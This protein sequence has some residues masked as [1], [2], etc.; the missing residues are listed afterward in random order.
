MTNKQITGRDK[1]TISRVINDW[2]NHLKPFEDTEY[3][4][5][6]FAPFEHIWEKT[7]PSQPMLVYRNERTD[8]D[9]NY[10]TR[11]TSWSD[12][13]DSIHNFGWGKRRMVWAY[14]RPEHIL[15]QLTH[16]GP[17]I[18]G[19]QMREVIV[20]PGK[21]DIL[22]FNKLDFFVRPNQPKP[23]KPILSESVFKLT[24]MALKNEIIKK[25]AQAAD[26]ILSKVLEE[27][28]LSNL[29]VKYRE[30]AE[31]I[32]ILNKNGTPYPL[33]EWAAKYMASKPPEGLDE[34]VNVVITFNKNKQKIAAKHG[35][36]ATDIFKYKTL[37]DIQNIV[38]SLDQEQT[39][40]F[41]QAQQS[42]YDVIFEN[43][44]WKVIFPKTKRAS[45]YFGDGT[46]W[47]T[48]YKAKTGGLQ[49]Q[50]IYYSSSNIFLSYFINKKTDRAEINVGFLEGKPVFNGN[51]GGVSVLANN[52]GITRESFD[53]FANDV[54]KEPNILNILK[55]WY[56]SH[57]NNQH[58]IVARKDDQD[59]IFDILKSDHILLNEMLEEGTFSQNKYTFMFRQ[60]YKTH[61]QEK[62][63]IEQ[64]IVDYFYNKKNG[65]L[66]ILLFHEHFNNK[67][68]NNL[69]ILYMFIDTTNIDKSDFQ[70]NGD[71]FSIRQKGPN[72]MNKT[73]KISWPSG[74]IIPDENGYID[75]V[76]RLFDS[77]FQICKIPFKNNEIDYSKPFLAKDCL[78]YLDENF[79]FTNIIPNDIVFDKQ[80]QII[81][82]NKEYFF[83]KKEGIYICFKS[84][85]GNNFI[86]TEYNL[87]V[88]KYLK[89][90]DFNDDVTRVIISNTPKPDQFRIKNILETKD[91]YY[92]IAGY[93]GMDMYIFNKN[94]IDNKEQLKNMIIDIHLAIVPDPKESN[95][96]IIQHL[97]HNDTEQF[98]HYLSL[99]GPEID[100]QYILHT[101]EK[102]EQKIEE[103]NKTKFNNKSM[104]LFQ[105]ISEEI[106]K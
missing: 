94:K 88:E 34:I 58:P 42:E 19:D 2:R 49:N 40:D 98:Q 72:G 79:S 13:P 63:K 48:A 68:L 57:Y 37:A 52:N 95:S 102:K 23:P 54:L 75:V 66:F 62:T 12:N 74:E 22:P 87:R 18:D 9:N 17:N 3:W 27:S 89:F 83:Y 28:K 26:N 5:K 76:L 80:K 31:Q 65:I 16:F 85:D 84:K 46:A 47:C 100:S 90:Y 64:N 77:P 106:Y 91:Y 55:K 38:L 103:L 92:Y 51:H 24:E 53:K 86:K 29:L 8:I 99:L 30:F 82:K 44:D 73:Y 56:Q 71:N 11:F 60:L 50:Y 67:C 33:I 20:R 15:C 43:E 32:D 14:L 4:S 25:R 45:I 41:Y 78:L 21:Y 104:N 69:H 61:F 1:M 70:V 6:R 10:E 59:F 105:L 97:A 96:K 81:I 36:T 39:R 7:R 93:A 101:K 35:N